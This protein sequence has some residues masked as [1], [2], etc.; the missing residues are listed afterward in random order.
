MT[1]SIIEVEGRVKWFNNSKGFGFIKYVDP[2]SKRESEAMVHFN[3]IDSE[4]SFKKLKADQTVSFILT[5]TEQGP[6]ATK[7]RVTDGKA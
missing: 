2:Q 5:K 1:K 7:V 4:L 6:R 3:D